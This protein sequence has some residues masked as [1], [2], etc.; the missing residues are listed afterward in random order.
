MLKSTRIPTIC[1]ALAALVVLPG[2]LLAQDTSGMPDAKYHLAIAKTHNV[3]ATDNA[4]LLKKYAAGHK[5]V[6]A[7]VM[8]E[9]TAAMNFHLQAARKSYAKLA[10]TAKANPNQKNQADLLKQIDVIDKRLAKV[11][12]MVKKL[13]TQSSE[14]DKVAL[15][16]AEISN[17]LAA[18]R[19]ASQSVDNNFYNMDSSNY[20]E[21]GLG[22][23]V[24]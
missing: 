23:F 9:H 14:A 17:E 8:K 10:A 20:Y 11:N 4:L 7:D 19:A 15:Q 12:D 18:N 22:H 24:D 13:E 5:T 21:D 6:P 3:H 16:A 2:R 1:L